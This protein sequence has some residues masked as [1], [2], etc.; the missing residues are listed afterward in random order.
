MALKLC[1]PLVTLRGYLYVFISYDIQT[2]GLFCPKAFRKT[3]LQNH[4]TV[5]ASALVN[6]YSKDFLCV[7]VHI[8]HDKCSQIQY[9][10]PLESFAI[11]GFSSKAIVLATLPQLENKKVSKK[12]FGGGGDHE[13]F[14][15][16]KYAPSAQQLVTGGTDGLLRVW[17]PAQ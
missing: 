4:P 8:F 10:P 1:F 14:T 7:E 17:F 5:D 11:C 2:N 6:K 3:S 16:V 15:C 9:F 13:F 12:F